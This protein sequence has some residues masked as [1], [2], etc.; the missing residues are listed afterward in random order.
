[1]CV[2]SAKGFTQ[3]PIIL[4]IT[5]A[6]KKLTPDVW[7]RTTE[8]GGPRQP[9]HDAS[10]VRAISINEASKTYHLPLHLAVTLRFISFYIDL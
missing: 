5:L 6:A 10:G 4:V 3:K 2:R 9:T 7:R 1:M 8:G